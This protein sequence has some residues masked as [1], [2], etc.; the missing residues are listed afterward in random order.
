[1][2]ISPWSFVA[3]VLLVIST[4][5][6]GTENPSSS[7]L[8]SREFGFFTVF[9]DLGSNDN[10]ELLWN[11]ALS[12]FEFNQR[13][14]P[15]S[16][17]S[18]E[19][20]SQK[21]EL[22]V[23]LDTQHLEFTLEEVFL[24]F[25]HQEITPFVILSSD[26][27][28]SISSYLIVEKINTSENY[29]DLEF[30]KYLLKNESNN[31]ECNVFIHLRSS[32]SGR[33]VHVRNPCCTLSGVSF[34]LFDFDCDCTG[35]PFTIVASSFVD[36]ELF[37]ITN[38]DYISIIGDSFFM[39]DCDFDADNYVEI[40]ASQISIGYS[41]IGTKF[42]D[43][44]SYYIN[45]ISSDGFLEIYEFD[46]IAGS[47]NFYG[48]EDTEGGGL[49]VGNS[50]FTY[51]FDLVFTGIS[52]TGDIGIEISETFNLIPFDSN[53]NIIIVGENLL[54]V[55][56][57]ISFT[58]C[59][60]PSP[61][62]NAN[63]TA[64]GGIYF[65]CIENFDF[66]GNTVID[67]SGSNGL[68]FE[69]TAPV[70]IRDGFAAVIVDAT[71]DIGAAFEG[72]ISFLNVD[73]ILDINGACVG[74][75][76]LNSPLSISS[77]DVAMFI[78]VSES[79]CEGISGIEIPGGT[80]VNSFVTFD[81]FV[82][83]SDS[84]L[85]GAVIYSDFF[86]DPSSTVLMHT[87]ITHFSTGYDFRA[88]VILESATIDAE[89]GIFEIYSLIDG[90]DAGTAFAI[91][92]CTIINVLMEATITNPNYGEIYGFDI[93]E[94]FLKTCSVASSF[95]IDGSAEALSNIVFDGNIILTECSIS[96]EISGNFG[97]VVAIR[98]YDTAY[99]SMRDS[100]VFSNVYS[101]FNA[102]AIGF[103]SNVDVFSNNVIIGEVVTSNIGESNYGV[104]IDS[105]SFNLTDVNFI[106]G[107]V[108]GV[109][110]TDFCTG[111][112][113]ESGSFIA[114][115]DTTLNLVGITESGPSNSFGVL[116]DDFLYIYSE[117]AVIDI[118]GNGTIG[119]YLQDT[120]IDVSQLYMSCSSYSTDVPGEGIRIQDQSIYAL[121]YLYID[122]YSELTDAV[123]FDSVFLGTD[124]TT[125]EIYGYSE[126]SIVDINFLDSTVTM[127][128]SSG[129][130]LRF[131][132]YVNFPGTLEINSDL[133]DTYVEFQYGGA[134]T[135]VAS[136]N[137][138][139]LVVVNG[140]DLFAD[141]IV[142]GDSGSNYFGGTFSVTNYVD[143]R[144]TIYSNDTLDI[145]ADYVS[146]YDVE[147]FNSSPDIFINCNFLD[148]FGSVSIL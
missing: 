74:S 109:P 50:N 146:I 40:M 120:Y 33:S 143:V 23:V 139:E 92:N 89:G 98:F 62:L 51:Q 128:L 94:S 37:N 77:S 108:S 7:V 30:S 14:S 31:I 45:V 28:N 52:L 117:Y 55:G 11:Q 129:T 95:N 134:I 43:D 137:V 96:S 36:I 97:N 68:F 140:L 100:D 1:M 70:Q 57:G 60:I 69:D 75:I 133:V 73:A 20:F 72:G 27:F 3:V 78:Y 41:S 113:V 107:L 10:L 110:C 83:I 144:G 12:S 112:I 148:L 119:C 147:A 105:L 66:M 34:S 103:S 22:S 106:A 2:R 91:F 114:E 61:F 81:I 15:L 82:P 118:T 25:N 99:V 138:S 47:M 13:Y 39:E 32:V 58:N 131:I 46:F 19:I 56:D 126:T 65:N 16:G 124:D 111:L 79:G 80:I 141:L 85:L 104:I 102:I 53:S 35:I 38:A 132:G 136:F 63:L 59:I 42:T 88:G 87:N 5:V 21:Q 142:Y 86:V 122:G 145:L 48:I 76:I 71:D 101:D 67:I 90:P 9:A 26:E 18:F 130:N 127:Y 6:L 8:V 24:K 54:D 135:G 93:A 29:F 49:Y 125:I 84:F 123:L 17:F 64:I 4:P 116:L 44:P 115:T 121:D